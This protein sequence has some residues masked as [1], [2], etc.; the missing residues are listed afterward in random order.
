MRKYEGLL[1]EEREAYLNMLDDM[2]YEEIIEYKKSHPEIFEHKGE[3]KPYNMTIEEMCKKY[4]L[5]DMTDFF[6]KI[7]VKLPDK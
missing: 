1:S 4:D 2:T 7:G 5:V 3:I 6:V